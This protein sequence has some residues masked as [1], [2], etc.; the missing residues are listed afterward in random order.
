MGYGEREDSPCQTN[1]PQ[2]V[3]RPGFLRASIAFVLLAASHA[4]ASADF[5]VCNETRSLINLAV[6]TNAGEVFSTEGWWTVTPGSCATLVRGPL[7]GRYLYLYATDINGADVLS[8]AVSMCIDRG[9]FKVF[10]IENCWRRGLQAVAFA[11]IDTLDSPDWTTFLTEP[12][13]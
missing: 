10:G 4:P 13:R 3:K 8:G 1:H 12:G 5:R 9:K 6:G 2:T 11:E 7:T